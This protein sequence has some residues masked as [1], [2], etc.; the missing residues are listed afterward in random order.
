MRWIESKWIFCFVRPSALSIGVVCV[1]LFTIFL[2]SSSAYD[3]NEQ[4]SISGTVTGAYQWFEKTAGAGSDEDGGSG[5]LDLRV[6][7]MPWEGGEFSGRASFG[8]GNGIK[9]KSPFILTPNADDLE[10]D[11]KN[12][13]GHKWQDHLQELW[14]AHTVQI[15]EGTSIKVTGGIIDATAFIDDN[16]YANDE[17]HQ[18]MNE[19]FVNNPLANLPSYDLGGA[20]EFQ[21]DAFHIRFVGMTSKNDYENDYAYFGLQLGYK[22]DTPIGEGNYRIYGFIT[23]DQFAKWDDSGKASLKGVGISFDQ[24]LVKDILGAF[25]RAGWQDDKAA[26]DYDKLVSFGFN[27]NGSIWGR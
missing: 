11:L 5:V 25:L 10:D 2:S 24:Q 4:L 14:Y 6:S 23:N 19:A 16:A 17:L 8:K 18:F 21:M 13:N 15:K 3:V 7:V 26:V 20:V 1:L 12:I 27:I 22:L 9:N